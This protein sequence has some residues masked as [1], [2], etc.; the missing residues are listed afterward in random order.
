MSYD[1]NNDDWTIPLQILASR[2]VKI[3]KTPVNFEIEL[4]YYVDQPDAFGPEAMIAVNITPVVPNII[5][6]WIRGL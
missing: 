3:G 6:N 4:D 5:N 1:W 2:T